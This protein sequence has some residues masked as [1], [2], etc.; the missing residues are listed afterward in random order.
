[1]NFSTETDRFILRKIE[2]TDVDGLFQ[3]E[4]T[5]EVHRYL[6]LT[7]LQ[8]KAQAEKIID[9]IQRQYEANGIGRWAVIDKKTGDFV[10]WSGSFS[11]Q[12]HSFANRVE[13]SRLPAVLARTRAVD[14]LMLSP[15]GYTT[16][17]HR[18]LVKHL[19]AKGVRH[20]TWSFHSPSVVPGFSP[21]VS[22]E[23]E[24]RKF[25]DS[26][27]QFFDFFFG[28]LGGVAVTPTQLY[29]QLIS[30]VQPKQ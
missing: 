20:F 8:N 4:S 30:G 22:S 15:E 5:P 7:P 25:L 11:N 24:L 3:M 12:L 21:Y 26:F 28:E 2:K 29:N 27:K 10:G 23:L 13:W 19:L 17:E 1:M 18:L 9:H 6:G 14:R 16:D